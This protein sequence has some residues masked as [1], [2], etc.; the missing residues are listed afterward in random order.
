MPSPMYQQFNQPN[1]MLQNLQ[2]LRSNPMALLSRR[3]NIPQGLNDPQQ[4][5]QHLL[6]TRQITQDQV[7]NAMRMLNNPQLK[8]LMK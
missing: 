3:F 5:I 6:N 1:Q 8:Q 7:N 4:I 2:L